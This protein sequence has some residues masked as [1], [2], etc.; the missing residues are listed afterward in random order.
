MTVVTLPVWV[1]VNREGVLYVSLFF[2]FFMV[3]YRRTSVTSVTRLVLK[4]LTCDMGIF[5]SDTT[6]L[7][8]SHRIGLVSAT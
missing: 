5:C 7:Q 4:N 1:R 8:V 6:G 2:L 3:L